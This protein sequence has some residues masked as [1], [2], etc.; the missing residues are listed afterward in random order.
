MSKF[1]LPY[2]KLFVCSVLKTF[3]GF[4]I[5]IFTLACANL[6]SKLIGS[7]VKQDIKSLAN[8]SV[9]FIL[10]IIGFQLFFYFFDIFKN[11]KELKDKNGFRILVYK[12]LFKQELVELLKMDPGKIRERLSKDLEKVMSFIADT[13]PA[14]STGILSGAVYFFFITSFNK[15]LALIFLGI[16]FAQLIPPYII[17]KFLQQSYTKAAE[18]GEEWMNFV[19]SGQNGLASI[20]VNGLKN[21]YANKFNSINQKNVEVY[22]KNFIK[23]GQKEALNNSIN[24]LLTYGSYAIIG[25]FTLQKYISIEQAVITVV[26]SNNFFQSTGSIYKAF[27]E[28]FLF[29]QARERVSVLSSGSIEKTVSLK[30]NADIFEVED[31]SFSYGKNVVFRNAE[32]SICK[33]KIIG[34]NGKNGTGK[35]TLLKILLGMETNYTGSVKFNGID[36]RSVPKEIIYEHVT[37]IAQSDPVFNIP[38]GELLNMI[39][40]ACECIREDEDVILQRFEI[41]EKVLEAENFSN[42]SGGERKKIYLLAGLIRHASVLILDEPT[43]GLDKESIV[44]LANLLKSIK[45][46]IILISHDERITS[47]CDTVYDINSYKLIKL[48]EV[49]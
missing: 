41:N 43:N 2:E 10:L 36:I 16:S 17:K 31:L 1:K 44:H 42:I 5:L 21:W 49:N 32:M 18:V 30:E 13:L 11:Q 46:T 22:S 9:A 35:S 38:P 12:L 3:E 6:S 27:S 14:I 37:Y 20:K 34:I 23:V 24:A 40:Q 48:G 29:R 28:I 45:K 39:A 8:R 4:L 26:L 15:F 7:A 33:N 25:I 47:L 19:I